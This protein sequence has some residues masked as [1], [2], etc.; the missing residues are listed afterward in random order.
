MEQ[1]IGED[2][3]WKQVHGDVFRAPESLTLYSACYGT[4]WQ[5]LVL[6]LGVILYAMAGNEALHIL[7]S[8]SNSFCQHLENFFF[9]S[10]RMC[11]LHMKGRFF[12][13]ALCLFRSCA[14]LY[15]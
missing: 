1:V 13:D 15:L 7:F 14:W 12:N 3:G 6:V 4:G 2:S 8:M 11:S 10:R 9:S 5:L